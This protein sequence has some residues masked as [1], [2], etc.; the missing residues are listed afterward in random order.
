[1]RYSNDPSSGRLLAAYVPIP[2]D[3]ALP[4]LVVVDQRQ[5]IAQLLRQL[6]RWLVDLCMDIS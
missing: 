5:G 1:M 2:L 4:R 6:R 3:G